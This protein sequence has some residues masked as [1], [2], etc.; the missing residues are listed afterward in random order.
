MP[1][2]ELDNG[3][4]I[5]EIVPICEYLEEKHP[6]PPLI[7]TTPEERAE[8]RMWTRRIDLNIC[9]PMGNGFRYGE[10]QKFFA[11]RIVTVPEA[12]DGLK[13]VAANRIAWLDKQMDGKEFICGKRFTMADI[14]LFCLAGFFAKNGQ[15][16]DPANTNILAWFERVKA[17]PSSNA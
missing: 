16:V 14:L 10:A 3:S 5:S 11:N 17:R 9:E 2:L 12:S 13:K 4:F 6:T 15:T 7:G 8:C 1:A